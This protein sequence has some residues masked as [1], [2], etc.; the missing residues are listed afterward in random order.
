MNSCYLGSLSCQKY[1]DEIELSSD[2]GE[3]QRL[4]FSLFPPAIVKV[5]GLERTAACEKKLGLDERLFT[6]KD[7]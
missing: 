3:M 1:L 6:R 2:E 5:D 7:L 4:F